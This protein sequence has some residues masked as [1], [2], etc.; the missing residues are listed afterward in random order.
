MELQQNVCIITRILKQTV[1]LQHICRDGFIL[2]IKGKQLDIFLVFGD[3]T[4]LL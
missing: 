4:I 1:R 3:T 2:Y